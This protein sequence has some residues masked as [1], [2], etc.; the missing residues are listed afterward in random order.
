MSQNFLDSS[1]PFPV[2]KFP[3]RVVPKTFELLLNQTYG[4]TL[5]KRIKEVEFDFS[6]VQWCDIFELSLISLW[7]LELVQR[8]IR[9]TF[10]YPLDRKCHQ[11]L[12]TY[13]FDSFLLSQNVNRE[14]APSAKAT[15]ERPNLLPSPY[16]PLTFFNEDRLVELLEDLSHGNRLQVLLEEIKEA[17]IVKS[18]VIRDVILKEL[19]DNIIIHGGVRFAYLIMTKFASSSVESSATWCQRLTENASNVEK[20][21]FQSLRGKPFLALV[22][23][24]KGDGITSSLARSYLEDNVVHGEKAPSDDLI[25]EY[26]FLYHSTR[27][28]LEQRIGAIKD[29]ISEEAKKYPP[30]TGLFRLKEKVREFRGFL[31]ARSGGAIAAFDF[32]NQPEM[33]RPMFESLTRAN[34]KTVGFGG[35]QFKL[36]FPLDLPRKIYQHKSLA[37]MHQLSQELRYFCIFMKNYSSEGFPTPE[38]EA[39]QLFLIFQEIDRIAFENKDKFI[40]I[41]L[42][43]NGEKH[44]SAKATH[45]L[46][47]ESMQRQT[48]SLSIIAINIHFDRNQWQVVF[49]NP[50]TTVEEMRPL[51]LFDERYDPHFFGLSTGI[52]NVLEEVILDSPDKWD[53]ELLKYVRKYNHIF[54]ISITGTLQ[55]LHSSASVMNAAREFTRAEL[56]RIVLLPSTDI[57]HPDAKVLLPSRKYCKGFFEIQKLLANPTSKELLKSW[58]KYLIVELKPDFVLSISQHLGAVVEEALTEAKDIDGRIVEHINLRTP[59]NEVELVRLALRFDREKQGVIV[60]EVVGSADTLI[61]VLDKT[62]HTKIL[63]I[64]VAVNSGEKGTEAVEFKGKDYMVSSLLTY[65]LHYYPVLPPGWRYSEILQVGSKNHLLLPPPAKP[66]GPLWKGIELIQ[67]TEEGEINETHIN[68]FLDECVIPTDSFLEGHFTNSGKHILYLFNIPSIL[69]YF[70]EDIADVITVHLKRSLENINPPAEVTHVM[71]LARNPG[72]RHLANSLSARFDKSS[73]VQLIDTTGQV[74]IGGD[75]PQKSVGAV[76]IIDDAIV[77]GDSMFRIYDIVEQ[78]NAQQIFAYVLIKRGADNLVRRFEKVSEYGHAKVQTRYLTDVEIP[79]YTEESCPICERL[80]DLESLIEEFSE[81]GPFIDFLE[82]QIYK[83]S[84]VSVEAV[85]VDQI[86]S[87][88]GTIGSA[89]LSLVLR[90][91]LELARQKSGMVARKELDSITRGYATEPSQTLTLFKVIAKESSIFLD[92]EQT[93]KEVFYDTFVADIVEACHCFLQKLDALSD[94]EFEAVICLIFSLDEKFRVEDL[95]MIA[96]QSLSSQ[97]KFLTLVTQTFFTR[98]T[99]DSPGRTAK[100]FRSLADEVKSESGFSVLISQLLRYWL[101]REAEL[102]ELQNDR[103]VWFKQLTGRL[104]HE[105]GHLKD[106]VLGYLTQNTDN[107]EAVIKSWIEFYEYLSTAVPLLR[108]FSEA[109]VSLWLS[110]KLIA[111]VGAIEVQLNEAKKIVDHFGE[112]LDQRSTADIQNL[113]FVLRRHL[114]RIFNLVSGKGGVHALLENFKT[115]VKSTA[116]QVLQQQAE[117]LKANNLSVLRNFPEESC[118]VFG[119][120]TFLIQIFQNLLENV[121]KN[122]K[123][124]VLEIS[125]KL[126][127]DGETVDILFLDDGCGLPTSFSYDQGLKV[128]KRNARACCGDFEIKNLL[129]SDEQYEQGFRTAAVVTLPRL[130]ERIHEHNDSN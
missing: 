99:Y 117:D 98:I 103:I 68:Q 89:N 107:N 48:S 128:V 10:R 53:D 82:D 15:L 22:I 115:N 49:D 58:Y 6:R 79:T 8:G 80:M 125:F 124:S 109:H 105:A 116:F 14:N 50:L 39:S 26:S 19:I 63:S 21:F 46:F 25:L 59:I 123:A 20:A 60:S 69:S 52:T 66:E 84:S 30:A 71:Y 113:R 28:T 18:G 34:S 13:R 29:L 120:D 94:E 4:K 47:F 9:V 76:V 127:D 5:Q 67:R 96:Q 111:N 90:W 93:R 130:R 88:N 1:L 54:S 95:L 56:A 126:R 64:I 65:P 36:Y 33:Q 81:P 91:K 100:V 119:E 92:N 16:Y 23:G 40:S 102:K 3:E 122:A 70:S 32:Y 77:S 85:E 37:M 74:E 45:Y 97:R 118:V 35:T 51:L 31:Y 78:M 72:L 104:L 86:I 129:P 114:E 42:D 2:I 106:T 121:W 7:V 24:D 43:F 101:K 110:Q 75:C 55:P 27:R 61:R 12:V 73:L 62:Q 38:Q 44:L 87:T 108:N 57:F 112:R 83:L 41:I 11:F 17:E